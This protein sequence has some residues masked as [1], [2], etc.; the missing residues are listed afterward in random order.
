MGKKTTLAAAAATVEQSIAPPGNPPAPNE[1]TQE[2]VEQKL[3]EAGFTESTSA[4]DDEKSM[5]AVADSKSKN[6]VKAAVVLPATLEAPA[7]VSEKAAP[8]KLLTLTMITYFSTKAQKEVRE[9]RLVMA[10]ADDDTRQEQLNERIVQKV[11]QKWDKGQG[12]I[13]SVEPIPTIG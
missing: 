3:K 11:H 6:L 7:K 5:P 8:R 10:E 4:K 12:P 1:L 9:P 13:T 2:Q